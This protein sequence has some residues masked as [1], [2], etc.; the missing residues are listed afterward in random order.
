VDLLDL[1]QGLQQLGIVGFL[2]LALVVVLLGLYR[3]WWYPRSYV[4]DLRRDRDEWKQQATHAAVVT[5][6][7]VDRVP[8]PQ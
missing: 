4:D 8:P 7:A 5:E 2:A 3:G 1:A 6:K